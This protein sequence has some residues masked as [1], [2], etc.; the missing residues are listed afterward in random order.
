[1]T[2]RASVRYIFVMFQ[3]IGLLAIVPALV[4][5]V[6]TIALQITRPRDDTHWK[7]FFCA[8]FHTWARITVIFFLASF[9][10]PD[11]FLIEHRLFSI[12][13]SGIL[14]VIGLFL[15]VEFLYYWHHRW[16]HRIRFLWASHSVHH[17]PNHLTFTTGTFNTWGTNFIFSGYRLVLLAAIFIGF[18]PLWIGAVWAWNVTA[19]I[20]LHNTW[21][22]GFGALDYVLNSAKFHRLHHAKDP[23][24]ANGNYGGLLII[25]DRIFGTFVNPAGIEIK[26][27]GIANRAN[28]FNPITQMFY[29][30]RRMALDLWRA[31]SLR[32]AWCAIW[33]AA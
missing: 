30:W 1:M 2:R 19:Q 11:Q 12:S 16:H 28:S 22:P 21:F 4:A 23:T 26:E 24:L 9:L 3:A 25:F 15:A 14:G 8:L 7:Y 6:E 31:R 13:L 27:Y 29:E 32:E 5:L 20:W 10:N 33:H 18:D 17:A